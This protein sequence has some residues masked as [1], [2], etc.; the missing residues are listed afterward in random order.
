LARKSGPARSSAGTALATA[1]LTELMLTSWSDL[2][3]FD[4]FMNVVM[5]DAEEVWVKETKS[6]KLGSRNHLGTPPPSR[7]A[8]PLHRRL[9][10]YPLYAWLTCGCFHRRTGRLLLK[11]ENITLISPALAPQ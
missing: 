1:L 7:R 2:Q 11:G 10:F 9:N 8:P 5:D 4:E 3:G 6:K